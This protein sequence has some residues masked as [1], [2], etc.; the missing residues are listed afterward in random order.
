MQHIRALANTGE[1]CPDHAGAQAALDTIGYPAENQK[2][3]LQLCDVNSA[4]LMWWRVA[5]LHAGTG[6]L[7]VSC[8]TA[9][10]CLIKLMSR[11]VPWGPKLCSCCADRLVHY[12]PQPY[13]PCF[14][15]MCPSFR[16]IAASRA[17]SFAAASICQDKN[18]CTH[19]QGV[20]MTRCR[21]CLRP[22]PANV[23]S[24]VASTG[25]CSQSS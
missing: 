1:G 22:R 15:Q 5:R 20:D 23:P 7:Q 14:V 11:C 12:L 24:S 18:L 17:C 8:S 3:P 6:C 19:T 2:V 13:C 4:S 16:R 25:R 10:S 9:L 21:G